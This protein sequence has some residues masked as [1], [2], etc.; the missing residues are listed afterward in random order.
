[1]N[2]PPKE[3]PRRGRIRVSVDMRL[4]FF[5]GESCARKRVRKTL[6]VVKI[7]RVNEIIVQ[8][9]AVAKRGDVAVHSALAHF[10]LLQRLKTIRLDHMFSRGANASLAII[11]T[12]KIPRF[13]RNDTSAI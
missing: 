1:M 10:S 12:G 2:I 7:H 13:A 4:D 9:F 5:Y 3:L 11:R 8:P 6:V